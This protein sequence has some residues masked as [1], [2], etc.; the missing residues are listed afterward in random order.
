ME[1]LKTKTPDIPKILSEQFRRL[2]MAYSK[3]IN[4]QQKRSGSLFRKN[5][6]RIK[7]DTLS[8]LKHV[9]LYIH[10]NPEHHGLTDDFTSY[11]WSSYNRILADKISKLRK[12]DV[13]GWFN[14]KEKYIQYHRDISDFPLTDLPIPDSSLDFPSF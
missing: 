4:K 10:H 8:Y 1:S 5:F 6:K 13:I 11:P 2:F 14:N 3:A 12:Q 9:A 7:I